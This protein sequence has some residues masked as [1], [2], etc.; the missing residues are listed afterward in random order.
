MSFDE[1]VAQMQNKGL[2]SYGKMTL[3]N[4]CK[5]QWLVHNTKAYQMEKSDWQEV[6]TDM[7]K[8]GGCLNPM[9][10]NEK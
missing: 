2:I 10:L 4:V 8:D 9:E 5:M 6:T 7:I 1:I 3:N